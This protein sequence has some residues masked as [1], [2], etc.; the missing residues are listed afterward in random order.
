LKRALDAAAATAL[1]RCRRA[2]RDGNVRFAFGFF[3]ER[4]TDA[5]DQCAKGDENSSG[6]DTRTTNVMTQRDVVCDGTLTLST[7]FGQHA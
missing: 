7:E 4:G 1:F 6:D 2:S 3:V 5:D